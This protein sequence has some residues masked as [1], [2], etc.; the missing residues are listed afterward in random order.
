MGVIMSLLLQDPEKYFKLMKD[1][2]DE[3]KTMQLEAIKKVKEAG[4]SDILAG[5]K[6]FGVVLTQIRITNG[7]TLRKFV[8]EKFEGEGG[9]ASRISFIERGLDIPTAAII[10]KYMEL[11]KEDD[12]EE[13]DN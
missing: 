6:W 8:L 11:L 7:Y 1:L 13:T 9:M 3:E 4:D 10:E 5:I 12:C 2:A